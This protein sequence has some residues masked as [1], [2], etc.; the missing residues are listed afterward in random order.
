MDS[1]AYIQNALRTE[2][3][4]PDIAVDDRF[5]FQAT[6]DAF[7]AAAELLDMYKKNIFYDK[8]FDTAKRMVTTN[9][10]LHASTQ[11]N[12]G[13]YLP[14]AK[15]DILDIDSRIL[16]AI[17][18]IATESG[19]LMEAM[20]DRLTVHRPLDTVNLA[21]EVGDLNWYEAILIDALGADWDDVRERN[22]AKL[23]ARF[24]DKFDSDKAINR[25]L[26]AERDILEDTENRSHP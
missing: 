5:A 20:C 15:S 23:R 6:M 26:K 1:K 2:S 14:I 17:V 24:P 3:K 12:Q 25:D 8:P 21:E 9:N 22:I 19:E 11:L 7:I 4:V 18:G 16:H 13:H 10:L